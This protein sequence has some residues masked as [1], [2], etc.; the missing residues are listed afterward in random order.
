MNLLRG[1]SGEELFTTVI[2]P[3][4][5]VFIGIVFTVIGSKYALLL[6]RNIWGDYQFQM[7]RCRWVGHRHQVYQSRKTQ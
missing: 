3:L 5:I 1:L 6:L 7:A 4:V 2:V